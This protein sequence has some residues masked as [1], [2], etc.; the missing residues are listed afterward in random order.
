MEKG[1]DKRTRE[2]AL[3][4]KSLNPVFKVDLHG[5]FRSRLDFPQYF[6]DNL[7][8]RLPRMVTIKGP[9]PDIDT[10]EVQ[11][12][13]STNTTWVFGQGWKNFVTAFSLEES[14]TLIFKYKKSL[15]FKVIV[16]SGKTSC[17]KESSHFVTISTPG[18]QL[19][20]GLDFNEKQEHEKEKEKESDD[21]DPKLFPFKF[22]DIINCN[23]RPPSQITE[24]SG[25]RSE[26]RKRNAEVVASPETV[27]VKTENISFSSQTN[28]QQFTEK[29]E[30]ARQR[31]KSIQTFR[32]N[33]FFVSL[34]RSHVLGTRKKLGIPRQWWDMVI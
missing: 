13:T 22:E 11:V 33:S 4:W 3:Y 34:S 16:I 12:G 18:A 19:T 5:D 31:A 8:G 26:S 6:S 30:F 15:Y 1:N 2:V 9:G 14:D 27:R 25:S 10:W 20:D 28:R 24:S 23:M 17:E 32:D 21:H 7:K 29:I